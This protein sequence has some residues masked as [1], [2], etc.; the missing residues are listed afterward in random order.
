MKQAVILLVEDESRHADV[1]AQVLRTGGYGTVVAADGFDALL[2]ISDQK[3]DLV[4]SDL[5]MPRMSGF[6]LLSVLRRRYPELPVIA[7]S[8]GFGGCKSFCVNDLHC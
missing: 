3:P 6:E 5:M 1:R 8:A 4:I 2:K 7:M